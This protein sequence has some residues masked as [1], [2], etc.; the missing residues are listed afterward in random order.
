MHCLLHRGGGRRTLR[1]CTTTVCRHAVPSD[2]LLLLLLLL[3]LLQLLLQLLL[4]LLLLQLLLLR[5]LLQLLLP[6]LKGRT[7]LHP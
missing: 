3:L 5:L 1:A 4:L 7:F 6:L 2:S